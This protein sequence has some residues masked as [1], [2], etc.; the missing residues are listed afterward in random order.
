MLIWDFC[1]AVLSGEAKPALAQLSALLAQDESEVGILILLAGQVR[2]AALAAVLREN[3]MLRLNRGSF[4][5][6][7]VSAR[8][9]GLPAAKEKRRADQHLCARAGGPAQPASPG[10]VLVSRAG[11]HL[12]GAKGN[13]D[14]RKRQTARLGTG[15]FGDCRGVTSKI[16][17]SE[18]IDK[19]AHILRKMFDL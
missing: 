11:A 17:S 10:A 13:A 2:L 18:V 3:K 8:G 4:A 15:R 7:E 5:S 12:S 19:I 16:R 14:G 1:H 6:A 9:R